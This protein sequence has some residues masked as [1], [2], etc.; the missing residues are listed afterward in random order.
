M[1]RNLRGSK[2]DTMNDKNMRDIF[3]GEND[4]NIF[5]IPKLIRLIHSMQIFWVKYVNTELKTRLKLE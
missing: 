4:A 2:F 1:H 3:F 5:I